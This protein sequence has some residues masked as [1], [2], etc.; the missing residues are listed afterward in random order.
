MTRVAIVGTFDVENFGDLLF[1]IIAEHE[2]RRRLGDVEVVPYSYHDRRAPD[3]PYDVKS[4]QRFPGDLLDFD[5]VLVGGGELIRF[6]KYIAPGYVPPSD[7]IHHPTG[8]WL[9]PT[10]LAVVHGVPVGWNAMGVTYEVPGWAVP[11]VEHATG[12]ADYISVRDERSADLVAAASS[13]EI[14]VVPD[15]AFTLGSL[16]APEPTPAFRALELDRKYVVVQASPALQSRADQVHQALAAAAAEGLAVLELPI[17]PAIDDRT[18]LFECPRGLRRL[19][20]WPSPMLMAEVIA[21]AE[22]VIAFSYHLSIVALVAGVPVHRLRDVGHAKIAALERSPGVHFW[23]ADD[24]GGERLLSAL[25]RGAPGPDVA[26]RVAQ[27]ETH[28]DTIAAIAGRRH[29]PRPALTADLAKRCLAAM[30]APEPVNWLLRVERDQARAELDL[31]LRS[32]AWRVTAP[33]RKTRQVGNAAI[34]AGR[35]LIRRHAFYRRLR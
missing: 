24:D 12:S 9:V 33:L 26:E 27:L 20:D 11:I 21:R 19:A 4:L 35:T 18:G 7:E 31:V 6:D 15:T 34:A 28:W 29:R 17:S 13:A 5:L 3:W 25:G 14:H 16:L 2:L 30:E 1:P 8:Y 23:A 22:A 10:L 32:P